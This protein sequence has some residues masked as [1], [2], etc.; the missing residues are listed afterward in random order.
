VR[1]I[2]ARPAYGHTAGHTNYV[3]ESD[4]AK[5]VLWGDLMHVPAVQFSRPDVTIRYD[6]DSA[7]A[8]ETRARLFA[9][10]AREGYLV[11]AAH[12][13]FPGLGHLRTDGKSFVWVPSNYTLIR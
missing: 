4:G 7:L 6:S 8:A 13:P 9:E 3:V 12:I 11:G 10:A 1:G 5:L 2:R